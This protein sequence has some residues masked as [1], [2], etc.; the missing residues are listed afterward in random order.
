[1]LRRTMDCVRKLSVSSENDSELPQSLATITF[2]CECQ[3]VFGQELHICGNIEE[4]GNWEPTKSPKMSTDETTYPIWSTLFEI[5][6]PVGM[7]IEYKYLIIS[8]NG[9][10]E[11][12]NI[13][14]AHRS[15]T[16]RKPGQYVVMNKKGDESLKFKRIGKTPADEDDDDDVQG[17]KFDKGNNTEMNTISDF[18]KLKKLS[19][20]STSS[21]IVAS[22]TPIELLSFENNVRTCDF[23]NDSLDF[24]IS[25]KNSFSENIIMATEFLPVIVKR[26]NGKFEIEQQ[27]DSSVFSQLNYL[28]LNRKVN[29]L[30][31]GMLR[32]YFEFSQ[33]EIE[34]IDIFLRERR[35]YM[36]FP[37][38]EDWDDYVIFFH[39]ILF[40][41]FTDSLFDP[42]NDYLNEYDKYFSAYHRIN[43]KFAE[44]IC[45]ITQ[46]K[47]LI[48]LNDF[49]LALVP[50]SVL[51]KNNNAT[52]GIYIH[53]CL[54]ASD[55]VK[56]I[57]KYQ[58]IF[59]SILLCDVI[60]F[61][62][63]TAARNFTTI[64]KRFFGLFFEITKQGL[65]TLNY[66][67]RTII[68]HIKQGQVDVS[69]LKS[70][71]ENEQFRK[72]EKAYLEKAKNKFTV[73]SL[74]HLSLPHPIAMKIRVIEQI[75]ESNPE[76][77]NS[78]SFFFLIRYFDKEQINTLKKSLIEKEISRIR[79]KFNNDN[80]INVEFLT[81]YNILKRLSLFKICNVLFYPLFLE[82]HCIYAN[83][84]V[85]MQKENK[86]YFLILGDNVTSNI[87]IKSTIRLNPYNTRILGDK[88]IELF[89]L[90]K[91]Y[92]WNNKTFEIDFAGVQN[93]S[94]MKW[95]KDFLLDIKRV[96]FHDSSNKIGIGMGLNFKIMKLNKKF[97]HLTS[98]YLLKYYSRTKKR[99]LF[100]GYENTLIDVDESLAEYTDETNSPE[101]HS[102]MTPNHR[103]LKILKHLTKDPN[104]LIF[105]MSKYETH[106][107]SKFFK[108]LPN[109]GLCGE[110]GFFYK[111]P[112]E[113][114]YSQ[115]MNVKDWSWR[116]SVM[117]ILTVFTEKT[118]GSYIVEKSSCISW[119]YKH[120]DGYF[121]HIQAN[122]IKTHLTSIY[123]NKIDVVNDNGSVD[124]K[125]KNVNKAAFVSKVL[126]KM[127]KEGKTDFIFVVG[128]DNTDEEVFKYLKSAEK[129]FTNF[130][131]K[132][133]VI[134]SVIGKK[135]SQAKYYF[136]EVNDCIE[137]LELLTR[138]DTGKKKENLSAK[139]LPALSA[140]KRSGYKKFSMVD[141]SKLLLPLAEITNN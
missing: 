106:L 49:N 7:N 123:G 100:L 91:N 124:I 109:L 115:L 83:E 60:G 62:L 20:D 108:A 114:Y 116:E 58:E 135:P 99:V 66:F 52:I 44:I 34:D 90:V 70:F 3:T 19:F 33:E 92:K 129:Y 27:E 111:Y 74:D 50:N 26:V 96:K 137:T 101:R 30:W 75:L 130:G 16:I 82:G 12:E 128:D 125:P 35:Y 14:S 134:T 28:L 39:N 88:I 18:L 72:E 86:P 61:H 56:L 37:N 31:V 1:M 5:T 63:Y 24:L 65:I 121:G 8:Q 89:N 47:D 77:V 87:G 38:K 57:P 11:W 69:Y 17:L 140:F 6:L 104:N 29:V 133:K 103:L 80:I 139:D 113:D 64:L 45:E 76:M 126:Q 10:Y 67:G 107:I 46:E 51:Q 93:N 138:F 73:V 120:S 117:K 41:I 36:I 132:I 85:A 95:M 54:P 102:K 98:K 13:S 105:I 141:N 110:N 48:I 71:E 21:A 42:K 43:N 9:N 127:F 59:K 40:P 78:T 136:N 122:E 118:E 15:I 25:S 119:V 131:K 55:I 94:T 97:S 112:N 2:K 4:L 53:S 32:N 81:S 84:F 22:Q 68:I 23:V 79:K